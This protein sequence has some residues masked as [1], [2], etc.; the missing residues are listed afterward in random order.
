MAL[1][2]LYNTWWVVFGDCPL[3]ELVCL[4][5]SVPWCILRDMPPTAWAPPVCPFLPSLTAPPQSSSAF[6]EPNPNSSVYSL[7]CPTAS[8]LVRGG[9]LV[10]SC[11]KNE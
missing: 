10:D 2:L 6:S 7:A 5:V 3:N 4:N 9:Y 8:S 1:G 11:A